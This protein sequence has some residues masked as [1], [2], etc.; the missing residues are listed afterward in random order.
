MH[1]Y[2]NQVSLLLQSKEAT[3][4]RS[5]SVS[6]SAFWKFLEDYWSIKL[7]PKILFYVLFDSASLFVSKLIRKD[8]LILVWLQMKDSLS[9]PLIWGIFH[10]VVYLKN[11]HNYLISQSLGIFKRIQSLLQE[12]WL[13]FFFFL[14][15]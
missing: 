8:I 5:Q 15:F 11:I 9:V 14:T 4:L 1:S 6:V 2:Q 10:F 13:N 7:K 12:F 3:F